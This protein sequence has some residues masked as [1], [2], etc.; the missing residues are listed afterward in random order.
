MTLLHSQLCCS[1]CLNV[2]Y[3]HTVIHIAAMFCRHRSRINMVWSVHW[4]KYDTCFWNQ[5][6]SGRSSS[7]LLVLWMLYLIYDIRLGSDGLNHLGE[8]LN[9]EIQIFSKMLAKTTLKKLR[10]TLCKRHSR[11][12]SILCAYEEQCTYIVF[13]H[14]YVSCETVEG[15]LVYI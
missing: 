6:C 11:C 7:K 13:S 3:H 8:Q 5:Q 12:I 2:L 9:T 4:F 1:C 15:V 10:T 14:P